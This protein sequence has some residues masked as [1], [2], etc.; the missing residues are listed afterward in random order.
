MGPGNFCKGRNYRAMATSERQHD[1]NMNCFIPGTIDGK[2]YHNS[3]CHGSH[4]PDY[5]NNPSP[6]ELNINHGNQLKFHDFHVI[7]LPCKCF[8]RLKAC[9]IRRRNVQNIFCTTNAHQF[10]V[11]HKHFISI[12]TY[13]VYHMHPKIVST[14]M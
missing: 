3:H 2:L 9:S 13:L 12:T 6:C 10:Y 4:F 1:D 8:M 11:N 14:I 7:L 5:L